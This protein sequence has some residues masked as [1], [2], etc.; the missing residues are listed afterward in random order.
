M[1]R[2]KQWQAFKLLQYGAQTVSK[3]GAVVREELAMTPARR[4]ALEAARA[5]EAASKWRKA[6]AQ[7]SSS[8]SVTVAQRKL[9]WWERNWEILKSKV[10]NTWV[11]HRLQKIQHH[12]VMT[13]GHELAEDIRERW[14]T[15]DSPVVHRIQDLNDSLFGETATAMAYKEIR[16]R[17]PTFSL[18][19]FV[20][21]IQEDV[22]PI[23]QAYIK[24][25]AELLKAK[26]SREVVERCQAEK[27]ILQ[28]QGLQGHDRILHISDLELRE[29]KLLGNNP[30]I[31]ISFRTQQTH[32]VTDRHGKITEGGRDDILSVFHLWA[33]QQASQEEVAEANA[34]IALGEAAPAKWR[35]KEMQQLGMQALI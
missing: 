6:G 11:V 16:R 21:E 24:G 28:S 35:L 4:R 23:L 26:C 17:D 12:P 33:L 34:A 20:G 29:T 22:E 32:W 25:D 9:T 15:S 8:T 30:V 18:T 14:E 27:R 1:N 2:I 31:I 13:K 3:M 19:E 7:P 10:M 5:A